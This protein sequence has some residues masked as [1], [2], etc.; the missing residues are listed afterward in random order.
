[1]SKFAYYPGCTLEQLAQEYDESARLV[2][3]FLGLEFTELPDWSCC[4]ATPSHHKNYLL[5]LALAARNLILTEEQGLDLVA[6]CPACSNRFKTAH[7]DLISDFDLLKK[8]R[9]KFDLNYRGEIGIF[10]LLE[11]ISNLPFDLIREKIVRPLDRL[12]VVPYYGC[13]LVRPPEVTQFDDPENPTSLDNLMELIGAQVVPSEYKTE[14][15]GGVLGITNNQVISKLSGDILET[16]QKAGAQA[17]VVACPL[18]HQN[19]DLKQDVAR[20]GRNLKP[21]PVFYFT[22]LMGLAFGINPKDLGIPKHTVN[23]MRLTNSL[24]GVRS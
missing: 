7:H 24:I 6:P 13:F 15:C 19:L 1:M 11:V 3:K 12:R 4:G 2:G 16:A 10:S 8:L 23:P 18:C 22:Q 21:M 5:S 9:Q 14:C 17:I 20:S